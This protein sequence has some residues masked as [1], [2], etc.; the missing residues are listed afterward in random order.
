MRLLTYNIHKGIGGRDR[1]YDLGRVISVIANERPDL[2]CLQEVADGIPRAGGVN[3]RDEFRR[4]FPG[5]EAIYQTNHCFRVGSYGNLVLSRWPIERAHDV[6]L[7]YLN[8]KKRGAQL[9]VVASPAGPVHVI[10]WHLGLHEST[11]QWQA[12][13]LLEHHCY[14]EAAH[15]PTIVVGDFNDWR[16]TLAAGPFSRHG[17][18]QVTEPLHRFRS[19]PAYLAM[20]ALDKIFCCPQVE[21]DRAHVVRSRLA[22]DASDHLPLVL[23]FRLRHRVPRAEPSHHAVTQGAVPAEHLS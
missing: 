6:C 16:N 3:Q 17:L 13:Y 5:F 11:R 7:R 10:N 8:R 14:R 18:R 22:R 9:V 20:S 23:D 1:R 2:I 21:V 19:F 12:S 15:L 4:A